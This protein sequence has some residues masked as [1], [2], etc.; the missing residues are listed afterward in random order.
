MGREWPAV[1]RDVRPETSRHRQRGQASSARASRTRCHFD[2]LIEISYV[3][4]FATTSRDVSA[5]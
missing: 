1:V 2:D 3:N 4:L 5:V